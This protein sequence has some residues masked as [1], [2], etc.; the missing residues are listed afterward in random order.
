M[1]ISKFHRFEIGENRSSLH[2]AKYIVFYN[3][4]DEKEEIIIFT[5]KMIHS[6]M[7]NNFAGFEIIGAGFINAINFTTHGKSET[8]KIKS[9]N[10]DQILF[11][12][13]LEAFPNYRDLK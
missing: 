1:D 5:N 3:P 10:E 4:W 7:A 12:E 2:G 8:L 13:F 11:N 9:R 6:D